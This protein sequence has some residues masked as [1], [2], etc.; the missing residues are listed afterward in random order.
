M[1]GP[2]AL[3]IVVSG[4]AATYPYGG[5][6]WDYLQYPI[7]LHRLGHDVLYL[8]D[9]GRWCYRPAARTF[10]ADGSRNAAALARHVEAVCPELRERWSFRD[11]RGTSHGR[12]AE[13]VARFCRDAD[14]LLNLSASCWLREEY[15]AARRLAFLDSDPMYTQASVPDYL[16]GTAPED[17]R[18]RVDDLRR[19]DVFL[20]FAENVG[21]PGCRVPSELFRWRPTRQPV[22]LDLFRPAR[23][24]VAE[25]RR[26]LTTVGSWE[27]ARD[28]GPVV[29]GVR[30]G[31]KGRELARFLD[32]PA[33]SPLP[34]E[35]ALSGEV[36]AREL[37]ERGFRLADP[38]AVSS[39][40]GAYRAYLAG[41]LGEWSVAKHAY[42][43]SRSGWFSCR[44]ACYL[45]LGVP[46]VV[47][48][49]GFAAD[50]PRQE[51]V[52]AFTTTEEAAEAIAR[53]A[54]EPERHARAA[55]AIAEECFDSRR[56]L[57]DLLEAAFA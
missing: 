45:A 51:G 21:A 50:I 8:E 53:L 46:A 42:V 26:T 27:P 2:E 18:R 25:R 9:T 16:R 19:H 49:T 48:D 5:V 36:P 13:W 6:F 15:R 7:G 17:A 40:P 10:V 39:D 38:N 30:Y 4:L 52:L 55:A 34:I 24:P 23:R 44:T 56:V 31:G 32:L 20:T 47:Q 37:T 35:L 57:G 12:S 11:A 43:A 22:V 41:S 54:A 3:R 14:L 28:G 1:P 29:D 33:R